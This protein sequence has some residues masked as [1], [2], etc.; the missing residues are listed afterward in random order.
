MGCFDNN[1]EG[2]LKD[3]E[4]DLIEN[5][6]GN[7]TVIAHDNCAFINVDHKRFTLKSYSIE[8]LNS[9]IEQ[10]SFERY[11]DDDCVKAY[12][13]KKRDYERFI[14]EHKF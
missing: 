12:I 10:Y 4:L 13:A 3:F 7:Y 2:T 1:L 6:D 5:P 8:E 14:F 9:Y 11:V